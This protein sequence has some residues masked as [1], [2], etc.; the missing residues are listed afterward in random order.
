MM[1]VNMLASIVLEEYDVTRMHISS[2]ALAQLNVCILPR[3]VLRRA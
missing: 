2:L 3:C 1:L